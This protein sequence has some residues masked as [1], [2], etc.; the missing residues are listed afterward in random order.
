[1]ATK[2]KGLGFRDTDS[3]AAGGS[4]FQGNGSVFVI[5]VWLVCC[6][7]GEYSV[8]PREAEGLGADPACT[9]VAG[10]GWTVRVA[11]SYGITIP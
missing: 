7:G 2:R 1:M 4:P 8:S 6:G 3:L 9:L 11:W 5:F 10:R